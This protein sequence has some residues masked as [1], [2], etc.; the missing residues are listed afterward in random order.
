[1]LASSASRS[2]LS[3]VTPPPSAG[4]GGGGAAGRGPA[5]GGRGGRGAAPG[6]ASR[7]GGAGSSAAHRLVNPKASPASPATAAA[8]CHP[9]LMAAPLAD[10]RGAG[11]V[12]RA[13]ADSACPSSL[14]YRRLDSFGITGR[15][16]ILG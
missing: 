10:H 5:A 9:C 15:I 14:L 13:G 4:G 1:M 12:T 7:G 11:R 6:G 3:S 16:R 8:L 2:V